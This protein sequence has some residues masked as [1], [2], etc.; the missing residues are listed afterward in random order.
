MVALNKALLMLFN[1][2]VKAQRPG[3]AAELVTRMSHGFA[4]EGALRI[5]NAARAGS[6]AERIAHIIAAREA[7]QVQAAGE[8]AAVAEYAAAGTGGTMPSLASP[9]P[10]GASKFARKAAPPAA[11]APPKDAAARDENASPPAAPKETAPASKKR[12]AEADAGAAGKRPA[13]GT[14][15]PFARR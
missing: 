12:D 15:N 14:A 8:F 4:L 10:Q 3:R 5:A 7:L 13:I 11:A 9:Q 1:A 6:L 2:A